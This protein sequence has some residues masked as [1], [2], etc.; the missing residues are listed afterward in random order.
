M[1]IVEI[2]QTRYTTKHYAENKKIPNDKIEQ[3]LTVL[4]NSP[5]SVNSQPWHFFII[6]NDASKNKILPAIADFNKPRVTESSHTIVFCVKTPIDDHHLVNLLAQE[7]QDGRFPS[8]DLKQAQDQGRRYFVNLNSKTT[9][10]Q[11]AW[12]SKQLYIALGQLLFA[13]AAIGIDSTAIEGY[14]SAKMDEILDLK[15]QGLKSVVLASLGYRAEN[16]GNAQRPKSRLPK[17]QIFTFL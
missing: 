8:A 12:E 4:R 17:E 1:N 16:D 5:S 6:D 14:D 7:E 3:L 13:A 15:K 9:E 2:S 10:L 11:F